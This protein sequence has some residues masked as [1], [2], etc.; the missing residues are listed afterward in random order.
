M[1]K[2]PFQFVR[3]SHV[4][5]PSREN[6]IS[7]ETVAWAEEMGITH[8]LMPVLVD[9]RTNQIIEPEQVDVS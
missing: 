6:A 8:F 1:N 5:V 2:V 7:S 9:T 4:S 3:V